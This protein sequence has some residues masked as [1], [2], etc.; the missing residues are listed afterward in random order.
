MNDSLKISEI[1]KELN[2]IEDAHGDIKIGTFDDGIIKFI[3]SV[4][5]IEATDENDNVV[6]SCAV[7]QWWKEENDE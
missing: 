3:R 7:L 4:N 6:D 5:F 1:I 2:A